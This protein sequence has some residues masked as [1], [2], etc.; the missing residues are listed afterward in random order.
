MPHVDKWSAQGWRSL[1][2]CGSYCYGYTGSLSNIFRYG[3]AQTQSHLKSPQESFFAELFSRK[4]RPPPS[5]PLVP[6]NQNLKD[7]LMFIE[8]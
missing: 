6:I 8:Q 2:A 3:N 7:K 5:S 4:K 1:S